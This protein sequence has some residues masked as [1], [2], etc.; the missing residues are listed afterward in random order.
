MKNTDENEMQELLE[1]INASD[2]RI[3]ALHKNLEIEYKAAHL[4]RV[5]MQMIIPHPNIR[6]EIQAT[7]KKL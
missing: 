6:A 5:Q 4:L 1:A 3:A 7:K 2:K